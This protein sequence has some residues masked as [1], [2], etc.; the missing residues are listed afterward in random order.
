MLRMRENIL[1]SLRCLYVVLLNLR[2][3]LLYL[4]LKS[5]D[6]IHLDTNQC[7]HINSTIMKHI[8]E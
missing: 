4:Y 6:L 3:G 5:R 1:Q 2:E 8:C 7:L